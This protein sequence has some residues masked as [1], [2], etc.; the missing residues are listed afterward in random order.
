MPWFLLRRPLRTTPCPDST[1]HCL[2]SSLQAEEDNG[3]RMLLVPGAWICF[4]GFAWPSHAFVNSPIKND[5]HLTCVKY[6]T[7]HVFSG[8]R[9]HVHST[10]YIFKDSSCDEYNQTN[11]SLFGGQLGEK[12]SQSKKQTNK[13]KNMTYI[14]AG[15]I[16]LRKSMLGSMDKM[17]KSGFGGN[18]WPEFKLWTTRKS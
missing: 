2:P 16:I 9:I 18:K 17:G 8:H 3:S 4:V 11:L 10:Y 12:N 1:N 15:G 7:C 14:E 13:N 6:N 5:W